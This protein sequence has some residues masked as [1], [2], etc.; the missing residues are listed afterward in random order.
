LI[1]RSDVKTLSACDSRSLA[2]GSSGVDDT[3][4]SFR[5]LRTSYEADVGPVDASFAVGQ[6]VACQWR[7]YTDP[8]VGQ[9][10]RYRI[11][12]ELFATTATDDALCRI[13]ASTGDNAPPAPINSPAALTAIDMP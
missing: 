2:T 7:Q 10:N 13:A 12:R 9:S 3:C 11:N 4:V 1:D 6:P 5:R 8:T